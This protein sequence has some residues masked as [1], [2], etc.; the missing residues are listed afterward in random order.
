MSFNKKIYD[1]FPTAAEKQRY[2]EA[3][4]IAENY[5]FSEA[6]FL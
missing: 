6:G 5:M 2:L 4:Q 1:M 3:D